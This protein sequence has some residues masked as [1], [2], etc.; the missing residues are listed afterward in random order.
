[1]IYSTFKCNKWCKTRTR[2]A[3]ELLELKQLFLILCEGVKKRNHFP[4]ML[5]EEKIKKRKPIAVHFVFVSLLNL[6][7][8]IGRVHFVFSQ[9]CYE[10]LHRE[11][12]IWN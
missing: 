9:K 11:E 6:F 2:R 4:S 7:T 10:I 12:Q 8:I 1:M 3:S 5:E